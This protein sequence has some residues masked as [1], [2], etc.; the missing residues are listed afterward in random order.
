MDDVD[1]SYYVYIHF[2]NDT[3]IPF[4]VGRGKRKRAYSKKNRSSV[5]DEIVNSLD[6]GYSV[7]IVKD[8]LTEDESCDYEVE[9]MQKYGKLS[10][11][12]GTLV[13]ILDGGD[14]SFGT[15]LRFTMPDAL[16]ERLEEDYNNKK[17]KE[18]NPS[19]EKDF[20][21][22]LKRDMEKFQKK[23]FA[24]QDDFDYDVDEDESSD[25]QIN[26]NSD[27]EELDCIISSAI[28]NIIH[29]AKKRNRKKISLKDFAYGLEEEFEDMEADLENF[30]PTEKTNAFISLGNEIVGFLRTRMDSLILS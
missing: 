29:L 30:E 18:L 27:S 19:Q 12:T 10:D 21:N 13:N 22:N 3:G 2:D 11:G 4:Y 26:L 8:H 23:F 15:T 24:L 7:E 28:E 25:L 20:I 6:N 14:D 5:W 9:L 17:Y 1:R 16:S